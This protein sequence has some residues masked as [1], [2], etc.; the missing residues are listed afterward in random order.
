MPLDP[1]LT[2][3]TTAS[4]IVAT[5]SFN[6]I[7]SGEGFVTINGLA[8]INDTTTSYGAGSNIIFS[9]PESTSSSAFSDLSFVEQL[10]L[11]FDTSKFNIPRT[12][13]GTA[14]L[15]ISFA[16]KA[17]G[18][19]D[20]SAYC[21]VKLFHFDGSTETQLG[22]N[23]QTQTVTESRSSDDRSDTSALQ[24]S[25]T[26]QLFKVGDLLRITVGV[27]GKVTGNTGIVK[28]YHDP[29]DTTPSED[30]D[31]GVSLADST[32]LELFV[33]FKIEL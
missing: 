16:A 17:V 33:P 18:A 32:K 21:I 26:N 1:K 31:A 12:M 13:D 6:D 29:K 25:I 28:L 3:F 11:D 15:N 27:W 20:C 19:G 7:A 30:T 22:S 8:T 10:N 5:F 9:H 23:Q 24:F 2:K 4:P 14:F